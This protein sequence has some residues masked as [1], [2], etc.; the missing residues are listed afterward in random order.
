[1]R[2]LFIDG[3]FVPEEFFGHFISACDHAVMKTGCEELAV[4]A[5]MT[6][7]FSDPNICAEDFFGLPVSSCDDV[8]MKTGGEEFTVS[9]SITQRSFKRVQMPIA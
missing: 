7:R 2:Q 9:G 4:S 5:S 1:M 3:A 8:L 6:Q